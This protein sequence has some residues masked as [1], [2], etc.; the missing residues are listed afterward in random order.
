MFSGLVPGGAAK[1]QEVIEPAAGSIWIEPKTS[2]EFVWIP[3]GSFQMGGLGDRDEQ[4]VHLVTVKGFWLG[5][6]EV[7]QGQYLQVMSKNPSQFRGAYNPVEQVSWEDTQEF[8]EVMQ[9]KTGLAVR[10]PS[11]AEWEYACRAGDTCDNYS[12]PDVHLEQSAWFSE[13]SK[14]K[15]QPVGQLAAN[16]WGLYDMIGNV[17]EWTQDCYASNYKDVPV[18]GSA[19]EAGD[20]S[21]RVTRGGS[22]AS[23][24]SNL[25]PSVRRYSPIA[26]RNSN[27]GFRVIRCE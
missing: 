9:R 12:D 8:I 16:P 14:R 13:N 6:H 5:K 23:D 21:R 25:R 20:H 22:W 27:I 11:E 26:T 17:W 24:L 3:S 2:M 15:T 10:L 1:T 18:D 4:P 7:T 19:W